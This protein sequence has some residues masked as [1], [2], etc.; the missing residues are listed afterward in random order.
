DSDGTLIAPIA[1]VP[2]T[3]G[4]SCGPFAYF[5]YLQAAALAQIVD[6]EVRQARIA[7]GAVSLALIE[8]AITE[9]P[10]SFFTQL[11]EDLRGC[12]DEYARLGALL[13]ERCG[14][15]APP[16]SNIRSALAACLDTVTTLARDKLAAAPTTAE[17]SSESENVNVPA[18]IAG[19]SG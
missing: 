3:E 10:A 11:V 14:N 7:R 16:Q 1:K 6:E 13:D 18:A 17:T 19:P 15:Q 2:L 12:L 4:N 8:R 9:S 5:H